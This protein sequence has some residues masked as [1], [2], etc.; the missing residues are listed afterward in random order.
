[1]GGRGPVAFGLL[2]H[3]PGL[4]GLGE[5]PRWLPRV[6][7]LLPALQRARIGAGVLSIPGQRPVG[8]QEVQKES[9]PDQLRISLYYLNPLYTTTKN[10]KTLLN[11]L[12]YENYKLCTSTAVSARVEAHG[13][14]WLNLRPHTAGTP[15]PSSL[16]PRE[17]RATAQGRGGGDRSTGW[18]WLRH[19]AVAWA[20]CTRGAASRSS[21]LS[22]PARALCGALG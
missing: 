4:W 5:A 8:S 11:S 20:G 15:S 6:F 17:H 16:H 22:E 21:V 1:M 12:R 19:G 10:K 3:H 9:P 7:W 14:W 18:L 2:L 13:L